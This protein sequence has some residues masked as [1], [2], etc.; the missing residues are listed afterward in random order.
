MTSEPLCV[1]RIYLRR[2]EA[3][4]GKTWWTRVFR[5]SLAIH[6]VEEALRAG[7]TLASVTPGHTGFATGAKRVANGVSELGFGMLPTCVELIATKPDLERFILD[8][9]ADL[10]RGTMVLLEGASVPD[11]LGDGDHER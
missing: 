2:G 7:I 10:A 9:G 5:P 4:P 6:V 11:G 3:K 8:H 1:L